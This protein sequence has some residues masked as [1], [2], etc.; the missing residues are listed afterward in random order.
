MKPSMLTL[1][2]GLAGLAS[3]Q[4]T[5]STVAIQPVPAPWTLKGTVYSITL[6]PHSADLPTKAFPPLERQNTLAL[7]GEFLGRLGMIQ[8]IRYTESP[9]GPYDELLVVPGFF[10]YNRT[11]EAGRGVEKENVR[12]SRIYVSQKYTCW[13]GRK[14][15]NIPKHLARF[16]WIESDNGETAVKVYPYDTTGDV[17]ES[18][19]AEKPWFQAKFKPDLLSGLPF[20]T[21][22]YKILGINATLAQPPLPY[23]DSA[24][25]ELPGTDHWAATVPGQVTDNASLGIF[26]LDQ[27]EGDIVDGKGTNAV[28]DEHFPNFWPGLLRFSPGMKLENT[29]ITFSEPDIWY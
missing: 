15:W 18:A 1:L 7:Q 12:V 27:G 10:K 16:D 28:G 8:V 24:N 6:L 14:N 23:A 19:P 9:V 3:G 13:N 20:S 17:N 29:T 4:T 21:D 5:E 25:G 26:D 11:N 22:L 2:A